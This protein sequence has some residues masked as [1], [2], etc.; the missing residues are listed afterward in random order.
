[1]RRW[2]GSMGVSL[3]FRMRTLRTSVA[4]GEKGNRE[5]SVLGVVMGRDGILPRRVGGGVDM[6]DQTLNTLQTLQPT[7]HITR[8]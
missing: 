8:H 6:Y 1:M 7:R 4:F 2:I 3:L 5:E